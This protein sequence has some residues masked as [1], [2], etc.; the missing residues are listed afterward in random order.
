MQQFYAY[1]LA[2][3]YMREYILLHL[4]GVVKKKLERF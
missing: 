2:P 3:I 4:Y 1:H